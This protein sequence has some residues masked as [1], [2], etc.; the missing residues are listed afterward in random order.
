MSVLPYS[1]VPEFPVQTPNLSIS[2]TVI[3]HSSSSRLTYLYCVHFTLGF[4]FHRCQVL[5]LLHSTISKNWLLSLCFHL[6]MNTLGFLSPRMDFNTITG[7][8]RLAQ[9][10]TKCHVNL[11]SMDEFIAQMVYSRFYIYTRQHSSIMHTA[12]FPTI[13]VGGGAIGILGW[14]EIGTL[15]GRGEAGIPNHSLGIPIHPRYLSPGIPRNW[16]PTPLLD[17]PTPQ[18]YLPPPP[19]IPERELV[20][21]HPLPVNTFE[22]ITFPQLMLIKISWTN[23][24]NILNRPE[25]FSMYTYPGAA[26]CPYQP[27]S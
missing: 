6:S 17:I 20:P 22:N 12:R 26:I 13:R 24:H 16:I 11:K 25:Q 3:S 9:L 7:L 15:G 8:F 14:G 10:Q 2:H 4:L 18:L 27:K 1:Q 5:A 21:T 19:D 23:V